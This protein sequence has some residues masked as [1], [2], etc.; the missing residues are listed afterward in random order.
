VVLTR[1]TA[2]EKDITR[3]K[4]VSCIFKGSKAGV[5]KSDR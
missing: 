3:N 4:V 2:E 1:D 5:E